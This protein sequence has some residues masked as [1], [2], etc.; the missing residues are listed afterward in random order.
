MIVATHPEPSLRTIAAWLSGTDSMMSWFMTRGTQRIRGRT[1]R[2]ISTWALAW[3]SSHPRKP[4]TFLLTHISRSCVRPSRSISE[5]F[6]FSSQRAISLR[7]FLV[8]FP[9]FEELLLPAVEDGWVEMILVTQIGDGHLVEKVTP[10]DLNFLSGC[11][12]LPLLSCHVFLRVG[13]C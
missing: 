7:R 2:R 9:V 4:T 8:S 10:Q 3:L 6:G 1:T 5:T 11:V 13:K 12:I